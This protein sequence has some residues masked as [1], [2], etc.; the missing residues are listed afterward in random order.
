MTSKH[1]NSVFI[2]N[3]RSTAFRLLGL[4]FVSLFFVGCS[5]SSQPLSYYL[6]HDTSTTPP[7]TT[8]TP[9]VAILNKIVLPDYLKQRGLVV[10][11]SETGIHIASEHF[12][13]EPVE[14]G[15]TKSLRDALRNQ[16]VDLITHAMGAEDVNGY[17]T[18]RIDDFIATYNG[19]IIL[20]G[21]FF[22]KFI[23]ET[24]V[25][26]HFYITLPLSSDGFEASVKTMRHAIGQL[27][28]DI[29]ANMD[30]S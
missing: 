12:W 6:L 29:A 10:Q 25:S 27:A 17:I 3:T 13:A 28:V 30:R 14:E 16:N 20:R 1:I 23:D 7:A 19:D 26:D 18:L 9:S 11:T 21:E 24:N 4:A 5:S 2:A 15:L 8:S 22:I